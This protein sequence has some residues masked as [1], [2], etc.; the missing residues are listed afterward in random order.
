MIIC[1][2][3]VL[4][5]VY[6]RFDD[7]RSNSHEN[8]FPSRNIIACVCFLFV[9]VCVVWWN[10]CRKLKWREKKN[11]IRKKW[12]QCCVLNLDELIFLSR[13]YIYIVFIKILWANKELYCNEWYTYFFLLNC[14]AS[15]KYKT[16]Q[17]IIAPF[18][19][20]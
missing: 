14:F 5:F 3:V 20:H 7:R 4:F 12:V 11:R 6:L 18:F 1:C 17:R 2:F 8:S 16:V 19:V 10:F 9:C 13:I 15:N